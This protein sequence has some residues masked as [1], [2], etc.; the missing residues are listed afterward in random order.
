MSLWGGHLSWKKAVSAFAELQ[1]WNPAAT[2]NSRRNNCSTTVYSFTSVLQ[3]EICDAG[4]QD[5]NSIFLKGILLSPYDSPH[6]ASLDNQL[7]AYLLIHSSFLGLWKITFLTC[8][9]LH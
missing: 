2:G 5:L 6:P 4:R 1:N 9:F 8:P 3:P 7:A